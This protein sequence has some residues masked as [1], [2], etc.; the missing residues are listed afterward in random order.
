MAE[1]YPK[2]DGFSLQS[3]NYYTTNIEY[4][5]TPVRSVDA[6]KIARR[7]GVKLLAHEFGERKVKLQGFIIGS[8]SSDLRDKI[9]SFHAS[10]T[11]KE[12][13]ILEI[14]SDRQATATVL[15]VVIPDPAYAQDM[16]PFEAEL[17]M[18]D[19]FFYALQHQVAW[20]V[21]AGATSM[22]QTVSVSGSIFAEPS[23]KYDAPAGE[24]YTTTSGI[25]V[26]YGPTGETVTWSG[27]GD[28]TTLAYGDSVTFDYINHRILEGTNEVDVEGVFSR[29]DPV[30]TT[31]TV[32]FSGTA[33]GGTLTL[34]Y[35]PRYL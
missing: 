22:Q 14:E 11:S 19:P 35:Q 8:S 12:E 29:W 25:I 17:I 31:F 6:Q 27:T 32:T 21:G 30:S 20:S 24:G 5:T 16:V 13:G 15:S 26:S 18:A 23:I 3:D 2:F 28:T 9:D 4:R 33:A 10:V 1:T 7:P 34:S